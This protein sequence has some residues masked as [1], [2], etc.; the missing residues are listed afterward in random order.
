MSPK[1]YL[2]VRA[3]VDEAVLGESQRLYLERLSPFLPLLAL[4]QN[5]AA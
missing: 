1:P 3:R 2:I 5:P 4:G